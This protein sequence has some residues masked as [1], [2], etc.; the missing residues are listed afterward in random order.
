MTPDENVIRRLLPLLPDVTVLDY[1]V[2]FEAESLPGY[3]ARMADKI[4]DANCIIAGVSF[5]GMVALEMSRIV[6][7]RVCVL[8]SSLRS[9]S[10][11]PPWL[12]MWRLL[13]GRHCAVVLNAVGQTAATVPRRVRT[14]STTRVVKLAG[15]AGGWHRWAT[16]AVLG[17]RP[18]SESPGVPVIQIHGDADRTFPIRYVTPDYVVPGGGHVLPMTHPG[19]LAAAIRQAAADIVPV[20]PGSDPE[21]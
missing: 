6:Q 13:A 17:W 15:D 18:V 1:P 4:P 16:S 8:I 12:R 21:T 3:A 9:P 11:L 2:P 20:G 19:E 14:R 5:G 10:Q 7:P